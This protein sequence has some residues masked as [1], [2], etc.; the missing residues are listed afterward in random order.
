MKEHRVVG[1]S[2][3]R[4]DGVLI[5]GFGRVIVT[6]SFALL[7]CGSAPS[8]AENVDSL[9]DDLYVLSTALW[10]SAETIPVC[11]DDPDALANASDKE[12]VHRGAQSWADVAN[13]FFSG[14]E[15]SCPGSGFYGIEIVPRPNKAYLTSSLGKPVSGFNTMLV[16]VEANLVDEAD[17][18]KDGQMPNRQD[19]IMINSRHEWGH[20]LGFSHDNNRP[21]KDCL[22][23][24]D[25]PNGDTLLG[26][27]NPGPD[28]YSVMSYCSNQ[29]QFTTGDIYGSVLEYGLASASQSVLF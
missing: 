27:P 5:A 16:G 21:D 7:G 29:A 25:G 20:V 2:L 22:R 8:P 19:C 24:P 15:N 4:A 12:G 10:N 9:H 1:I 26:N 13:I 14:W 6:F 11:W 28:Y 3:T 17:R 18:C 23:D